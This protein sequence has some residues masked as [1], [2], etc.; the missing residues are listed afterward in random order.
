MEDFILLDVVDH[1]VDQELVDVVGTYL[2]D[3]HS[4]DSLECAPW[5]ESFLSCQILSLFLYDL[6]VLRNGLQEQKYFVTG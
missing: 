3:T 6:F 2:P 4:V 1:V 5:F